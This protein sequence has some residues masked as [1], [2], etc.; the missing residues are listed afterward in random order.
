[1]IFISHRGN[2]NGINKDRENTIRYIN[3]A[4]SEGFNVEVDIWYK[5]KNFYLGHDN[6]KTKISTKFL[7]NRKIWCHAKNFEAIVM[8]KQNNLHFFWHQN[9]DYVLT[10][11][12][13]IWTYPGKKLFKNSVNLMPENQKSKIN[14]KKKYFGICSDYI[15]YY[16]R[17]YKKK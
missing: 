2:I 14:F 1:M 16:K 6:P 9:D 7:K 13:I 8:S 17:I 11:K 15:E 10:S 4:L 3:E 5:N 12:G